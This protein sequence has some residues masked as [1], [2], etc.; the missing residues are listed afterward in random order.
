M[1]EVSG[2]E[3]RERRAARPTHAHVGLRRERSDTVPS[4]E[5]HPGRVH[6]ACQRVSVSRRCFVL[7]VSRCVMTLKA[8]VCY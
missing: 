6:A 4:S 7:L 5:V 8:T 3:L 1:P 2:Q